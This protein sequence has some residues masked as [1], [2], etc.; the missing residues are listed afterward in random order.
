MTRDAAITN[1]FT[2]SDRE[3]GRT[4]WQNPNGSW[5]HHK[6]SKREW[7]DRTACATDLRFAIEWE[8]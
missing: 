6:D 7:A 3:N 8:R 1:D 4:I 2:I 5:S